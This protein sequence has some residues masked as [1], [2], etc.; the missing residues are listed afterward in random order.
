MVPRQGWGTID[1][2]NAGEPQI[3][4]FAVLRVRMTTFVVGASCSWLADGL[5]FGFGLHLL[6]SRREVFEGGEVLV[7]VG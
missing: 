1:R 2:V 5:E 7:D 4:P 3:L 6:D